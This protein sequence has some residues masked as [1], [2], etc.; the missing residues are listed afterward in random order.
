MYGQVEKI[1][2]SAVTILWKSIRKADTCKMSDYERRYPTHTDD[3]A[4]VILAMA[5][6]KI[7]GE[8]LGGIFHW[9]GDENMTKY[10]MAIAMA[11]V[12]GLE[13][14]HIIADKTVS[15]GAPRPYN[16]HLSSDRLEAMGIKSNQIPFKQGIKSALQPY[17]N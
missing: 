17:V 13:T 16:A 15:T 5:E 7:K 10:D 12:F 6:R 1:E 11:N 2:E 8:N 4:S 14:D 3:V 9:S